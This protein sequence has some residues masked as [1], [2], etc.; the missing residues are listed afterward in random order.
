MQFCWIIT[1][2][3]GGVPGARE[4]KQGGQCPQL[5]LNHNFYNQEAYWEKKNTCKTIQGSI[6][7]LAQEVILKIEQEK[8]RKRRIHKDIEGN[9]SGGSRN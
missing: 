8:W 9:C 4:A 3:G 1:I 7:V 2:L 6:W 5:N